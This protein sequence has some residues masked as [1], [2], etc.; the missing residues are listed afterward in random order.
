MDP[1]RRG[2]EKEIDLICVVDEPLQTLRRDSHS[3]FSRPVQ[4]FGIRIDSDQCSE[5]KLTRSQYLVHQVGPDIARTED[6]ACGHSLPFFPSRGSVLTCMMYDVCLERKSQC[7]IRLEYVP[8]T[9]P[10]VGPPSIRK[11]D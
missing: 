2:I 10:H 11:D 1:S 5:I 3:Q 8:Q 7:C 4:P 6:C 9:T